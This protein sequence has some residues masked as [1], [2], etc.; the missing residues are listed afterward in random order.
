MKR[1]LILILLIAI[2]AS[3]C[4]AQWID[5][6]LGYPTQLNQ[7]GAMIHF[8]IHDDTTLFASFPQPNGGLLRYFP[9]KTWIEYDN[10][11]DFTQ[12]NITSFASLGRYFFA[13]IGGR[14]SYRSTNNGTS[15]SETGVA[16]PVCSNGKYL[17]A[18]GGT[19]IYRSRDSGTTWEDA[20]DNIAA[21]NFAAM[22][23]YIY[24]GTPNA[25][26]RSA[27]SGTTWDSTNAPFGNVNFAVMGSLIFAS[28]GSIL[29]SV[30]SGTTWTQ[31]TIPRRTVHTLA[32]SA[33]YLF[34]GTD[35]GVFISVDSGANWR[36]ISDGLTA[37]V[38]G[39]YPNA[40][41]LIVFDTLLF[42]DID[43]GDGLGYTV[44]RSIPEIT[45][46][47]TADVVQARQ[48]VD[49]IEIYPNPARGLV[50]I[51]ASGT[52][53]FGISVLNV[54]GVDMLDLPN[55]HEP[56]LTLDLSKLPSGTYFLRII[57]E[58]GIVLR[59]IVKEQ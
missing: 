40:I 43:A 56:N 53:I 4:A 23:A 45:K 19:G 44:A 52:S 48:P 21:N 51:F 35:S 30:D 36:N 28:H 20:V 25:I 11:I 17:F 9:P 22:G 2:S 13:G 47:T 55:Q 3:P 1:S 34:T 6:G 31:I 38:K 8:G 16:S 58:R 49:A 5:V 42:V 59:K 33:S 26:W 27:D 39:T 10:G 14:P 41:S 15:W 50:T 32:A 57:T 12:G 54:L 37:K 18:Y 7:Q 46:D 29:R 24:A